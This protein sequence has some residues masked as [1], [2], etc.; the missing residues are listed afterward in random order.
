[1]IKAMFE[2]QLE[3]FG[4]VF[5]EWCNMKI[6]V[7]GSRGVKAS[8]YEKI[9]ENI[10]VNC[11][12]IISG[13]ANGADALAE[14]YAEENSLRLTVVR[15]QYAKLGKSAPLERN[16]EIIRMADYVLAFWDGESH[17]TAFVIAKCLELGV[18][19]KVIIV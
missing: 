8:D 5:S 6:A 14:R 10:P 11:T 7:I 13:G 9:R 18:P 19:V 16:L 4:S 1:M 2:N 15:P 12:E 3:S 17:G